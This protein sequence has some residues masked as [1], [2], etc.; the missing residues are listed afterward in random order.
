MAT[1]SDQFYAGK[2]A[3]IHRK[4]GKGT[5]TYIGTDTDDG[6]LEKN[7]LKKV[8]ESVG[9]PIQELPEGVMINWRDGFWVANNYSSVKVN[10]DIPQN[11]AI[12]FGNREIPLLACWF[13]NNH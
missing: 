10:M 3:I 1:Y 9:I 8:Y 5:V 12:I 6:K 13:G 4:I 7:V 11:A 2:A